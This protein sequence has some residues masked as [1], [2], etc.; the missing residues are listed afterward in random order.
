MLAL[1]VGTG[2]TGPGPT[3][4]GSKRKCGEVLASPLEKTGTNLS[5]LVLWSS[6]AGPVQELLPEQNRL[7][8]LR[9]AAQQGPARTTLPPPGDASKSDG[10]HKI[11]G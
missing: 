8:I 6:P 11:R 7:F 1:T 5:V 9:K 3:G 10:V 4:N 2:R